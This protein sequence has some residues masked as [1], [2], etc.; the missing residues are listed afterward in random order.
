[1]WGR[2]GRGGAGEMARERRKTLCFE[3][4]W[5]SHSRY[6]YITCLVFLF[7]LSKPLYLS[8]YLLPM[9][10]PDSY[11]LHTLPKHTLEREEFY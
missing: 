7:V 2:A 10:Y 4:F 9:Y 3:G 6:I 11:L 8:T 5:V 1:M